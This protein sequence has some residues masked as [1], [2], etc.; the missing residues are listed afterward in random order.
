[1]S[2]RFEV[3]YKLEQNLYEKNSPVIISA[4]TLLKDTKTD[5][6][7]TQLKFQSITD[8]KIIALKVS[9][10]A[11]DVSGNP[12]KKVDEY[13]YL[14]LNVSNG[15][16]FGSNKAIVMPDNITR[17]ISIDRIIVV[18]ENEEYQLQIDSF[19]VLPNQDKLSFKYSSDL[20][21]Q[22]Q[23]DASTSGEYM[24]TTVDDLWLCS[25][26]TPNAT[27]KCVGCGAKKDKVFSSLDLDI[28]NKH[29]QLR[30]EK[31][32]QKIE[33]QRQQEA[34]ENEKKNQKKKTY[35]KIAVLSAV[36]LMAIISIN[37]LI[38]QISYNR[39]LDEI[40]S[41]IE[42]GKYEQAF[43]KIHTSELSYDDIKLY[44]EKVIPYMKT[45]HEELRNSS[46]A[47]LALVLDETE[48]YISEDKI[49]SK[50]EGES[51][52][53]LYETSSY[54]KYLRCHWSIYANGCLFFVE[55]Q[56]SHDYDSWKTSYRYTAKFIDLQTGE[57]EI[58]GSAESRGDIVKL[59][60]G[61]IFIGQNV[62]DFNEGILYNPYTK[63]KYIGEDAVSDYQLENKI[64]MDF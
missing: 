14:D 35:K 26:R 22:Y 63:S 58:L 47:N 45:A 38:N 33:A 40:D 39:I 13:Q 53:T 54:E 51:A 64:Y 29:L 24:P 56:K 43:D 19:K 59:D 46:K 15:D 12:T 11:F 34:Y 17:K 36:I 4:G 42:V 27:E 30:N 60:N 44:R 20:I 18:F 8:R 41:Y 25:C 57:V 62:L 48:Y 3:L 7:I 55:G 5:S 6:V 16:F 37:V 9:L 23:I 61:S 28:L 50:V 21:K 49:Y 52:I 31:Q 1:M 10:S 32:K 2:E